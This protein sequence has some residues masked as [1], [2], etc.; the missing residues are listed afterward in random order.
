MSVAG[1]RPFRDPAP[2]APAATP[3]D[4]ILPPVATA[5]SFDEKRARLRELLS[6]PEGVAKAELKKLLTDKNGY[7]VGEAAEV[8]KK[9]ELSALV[10]DLVAAFPRFLHDGV[11][12]DK[13]CH[14]KNHI[15]EALLAFDAYEADTYLAGLRYQQLEPAFGEPIDTAA[16]LRGLC[17]HALFHIRHPT[18]LL[19]VAP[20]LFDKE[21]VT[22]AE[23]AAALGE[24][25]LDGAAAALHVKVLAGDREPDV[26]GAA[27][28]SLLRLFPERYLGV[29]AEVLSSDEDGPA[30]AAAIAL[31]E[32]RVPGAF[33]ALAGAA[34][35]TGLFRRTLE[36]VLLGIALLRSDEALAFLTDLV[37]SAP[38]QKALDALSAL[39]LHR[40]VASLTS[41]LQT[42]V[43]ARKSARLAE[44]FRSKFGA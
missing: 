16:G 34:Q 2:R 19:D 37:D 15:V 9:L 3:N 44:S 41:R 35:E 22:R 38:E 20:L 40:H 21:A 23:A 11:K 33:D 4:R 8:T 27:Y 42:I 24:S 39:A 12:S 26:L 7:L 32:S 5:R 13:G 43:A 36:S 1:A 25:G 29:V 18:A 31:G 30:E 28:R 17:A 6:A 10:P 14:G